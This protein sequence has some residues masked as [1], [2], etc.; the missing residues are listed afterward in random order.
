MALA[1]P[2]RGI[3]TKASFTIGAGTAIEMKG[4]SW[5]LKRT[6]KIVEAHNT[7]DGTLRAPG[8]RDASGTV[9]A[10]V[11]SAN[12]QTDDIEDGAVGT[13]KLYI[14]ETRFYSLLAIIENMEIKTDIDKAAT[15]SFDYQLASG[16]ITNPV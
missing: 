14:D 15:I 11:D 5:S 4:S 8:R 2:I 10:I 9:E 16:V 1:V 13:L 3:D 6:N 7:D 12:L